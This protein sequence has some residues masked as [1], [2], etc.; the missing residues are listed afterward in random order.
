MARYQSGDD[1]VEI[2]LQ[3]G[4]DDSRPATQQ[5]QEVVNNDA[6]NSDRSGFRLVTPITAVRIPN[7]GS[8][9]SVQES[10]AISDGGLQD[11]YYLLASQ[12]PNWSFLEVEVTDSQLLQYQS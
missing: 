11:D 5:L 9:A 3:I 10:F 7:A 6:A 4:F 1:A 12:G 2:F 8:G